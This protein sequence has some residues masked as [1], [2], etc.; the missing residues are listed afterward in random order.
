VDITALQ[1]Q[2]RL[3][4]TGR[5]DRNETR[6]DVCLPGNPTPVARV[7]QPHASM[8]EVRQPLSILAGAEGQTVVGLVGVA[9]SKYAVYDADKN[10]IGTIASVRKALRRRKWQTDQPGLATFTGSSRGIRRL[11]DAITNADLEAYFLPF[12]FVFTA[13]GQ[14][15][16]QIRRRIGIRDRYTV[17]IDGPHLDRR[18]VLAQLVALSRWEKDT[19]RRP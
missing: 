5:Y 1:A 11:Y 18:L 16:F 12:K 14:P 8:A 10:P 7:W 2:R 15:G 9:G 13:P 4:V 17:D 6:F 3:T 19:L